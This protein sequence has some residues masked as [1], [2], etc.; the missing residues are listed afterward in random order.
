MWQKSTKNAFFDQ[1]I[2]IFEQK[3]T[4][5]NFL[6]FH[7]W[8]EKTIHDLFFDVIIFNIKLEHLT[9]RFYITYVLGCL[10]SEI[11]FVC[12]IWTPKKA[13]QRWRHFIISI[14]NAELFFLTPME[15]WKSPRCP[16]HHRCDLWCVWCIYILFW[17][18]QFWCMCCDLWWFYGV[19]MMHMICFMM[20]M[21]CFM[22]HF[23]VCD[24]I[25]DVKNV[26]IYFFFHVIIWISMCFMMHMM[27]VMWFM[28]HMVC[29]MMYMMCV[30]WFMMHMMCVMWFMMHMVC[31]MI[32]FDVC[33]VIYDVKNVYIYFFHVII[34]N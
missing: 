28:M 17:L 4:K 32:H 19:F 3:S 29:F 34:L 2:T 9:Q 14:A 21:M 18:D 31:F 11:S 7:F 23:D 12:T 10:E 27:C 16:S 5:S 8:R 13:S 26:Y 15:W 6:N 22:I 24:V 1:K 33:D 30:M 20:H 25:Y